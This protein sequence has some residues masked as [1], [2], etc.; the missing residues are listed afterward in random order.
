MK[1]D[2]KNLNLYMI[3][4][5]KKPYMYYTLEVNNHDLFQNLLVS[6]D[7]Y[8]KLM[9]MWPRMVLLPTTYR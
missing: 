4:V 1:V 2:I 5:K 8:T 6:K 3:F 7:E 9:A